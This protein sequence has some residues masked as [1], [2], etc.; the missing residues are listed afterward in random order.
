[1]AA[2]GWR[3]FRL[4]D[5]VVLFGFIVGGLKK[6][7]KHPAPCL[8]GGVRQP[9]AGGTPESGG[10]TLEMTR[11]QARL[12]QEF[13][14]EIMEE[15]QGVRQGDALPFSCR[16]RTRWSAN[17]RSNLQLMAAIGR[18]KGAEALVYAMTMDWT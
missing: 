6:G 3:C 18:E 14:T 11:R 10:T 8:P 15:G 16:I 13:P 5:V 12:R 7:R 17:P 1:V 9:A 2:E 4:P